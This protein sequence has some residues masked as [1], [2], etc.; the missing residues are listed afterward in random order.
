[1]VWWTIDDDDLSLTVIIL[2][3]YK[4]GGVIWNIGTELGF[5]F[6]LSFFLYYQS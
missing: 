6:R 4:E 1:M 3:Y 5:Q 2:C